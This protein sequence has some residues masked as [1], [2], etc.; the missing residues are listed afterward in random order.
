MTRIICVIPARMASSRFPGKPLAQLL[1]MPLLLHVWHRCRLSGAFER[2]VIATC[3]DEIRT[4]CEAAGAEVVMTKDTHERATDRTEEAI[5]K[6]NLGLADHDLVMMVQGDEV[7]VTPEMINDIV[8]A[9][10]NGK[11]DAVNL[12]SRLVRQEDIDDSNTVKVVSDPKD[13]V[14]YL[15]RAPIPS[16]ARKVDVAVYQQTGVIGFSARFLRRFS[17]LPQTPLEIVESVDM[18]RVIEHGLDLFLIR[19]E[20]ETVGVDN[21]ADRAHAEI[22]LE[23]SSVTRRYLS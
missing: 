20:I 18:L 14:L 2:V 22:L 9:Y 21:E 10:E 15:S 17:E 13:R 1:G 7:L 11:P 23:R 19:T 3:D 8:A 5:A 12:G 16:R 6:M 4:A